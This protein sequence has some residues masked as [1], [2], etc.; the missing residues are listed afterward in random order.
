MKNQNAMKNLLTAFFLIFL[1]L[2]ALAQTPQ[3]INY[4]G[5]AR[6][7]VG[8]VIANQD[9]TLR[10]TIRDAITSGTVIYQESRSLKTNSFGLFVTA[11]GGPGAGNVTGSFNGIDW[12]TGTK[13]LQVEI[14]PTGS[15]S[16]IDM[17]TSQFL[18]VPYALY[19]KSAAPSGAAGGDLTA[20]YPNPSIANGVVN[21]QK[22]ADNAVGTTKLQDG[23]VTG[24]KIAGSTITADKLA[25]G[26]IPTSI[27]MSGA[28]GGDLSGS[29]PDPVIA[30]AAITNNKLADNAVNTQKIVDASVTNPK[31]ADGA[32]TSTKLG[33]NAIATNH[34]QDGS[35]TAAKL[36]PG[37]IPTSIPVSGTA[38]G[39]LTGTYRNPVIAIIAFGSTKVQD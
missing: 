28:A 33:D 32:V 35:V 16:F 34:I 17:G 2:G 3:G 39:D 13:F 5:V 37:V 14:D 31:L 9:I 11:I 36:A 25:P 4:Q 15:T 6:N 23:A 29:Y 38:G 19:A 26:V 20:T 12:S 21:E 30:S 1:G 7:S 22:L 27:P 8:S 18:S 10:L 24:N